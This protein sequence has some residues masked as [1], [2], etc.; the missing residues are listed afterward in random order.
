MLQYRRP[1]PPVRRPLVKAASLQGLAVEL[2]L[3]IVEEVVGEVD[4]SQPVLRQASEKYESPSAYSGAQ[5]R[6]V[7][8]NL[9]LLQHV[10]RDFWPICSARLNGAFD[11]QLSLSGLVSFLEDRLPLHGSYIRTLSISSVIEYD[12]GGYTEEASRDVLAQS[13]WL[14]SACLDRHA[15]GKLAGGLQDLV[16]VFAD[17]TVNQPQSLCQ[18]L[19]GCRNLRHLELEYSPRSFSSEPDEGSSRLLAMAVNSLTSLRT[20]H[21]RN[22]RAALLGA[23]SVPSPVS[24][25]SISPSTFPDQLDLIH[26]LVE[27]FASTLT[28]LS[29]HRVSLPFLPSLNLPRLSA[30]SF[31]R[32]DNPVEGLKPFATL[33]LSRLHVDVFVFDET[34]QLLRTLNSFS[35][36]LSSLEIA[37]AEYRDEARS[38][39]D[40]LHARLEEDTLRIGEWCE[41]RGVT[42]SPDEIEPANERVL[43][44]PYELYGGTCTLCGGGRGAFSNYDSDESADTQGRE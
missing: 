19:R 15:L 40:E 7:C 10:D 26:T 37:R 42:F 28:S 29:I 33:P 6:R 31:A 32:F 27:S 44:D 8:S 38:D 30:L 16:V 35:S 23:L 22:F 14:R 25:L 41:A 9:K 1:R 39:P 21:L 24:H 2:K 18:L 3:R 11:L 20:L 5:E 17:S 43:Y 36:S 13:S 4:L 34:Q 12:W